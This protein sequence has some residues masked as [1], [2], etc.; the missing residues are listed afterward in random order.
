M[1]YD[2]LRRSANAR[3]PVPSRKRVEGSGMTLE[4]PFSAS[5]RFASKMLPV[6]E[7]VKSVVILSGPR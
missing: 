3:I 7:K 6:G 4:L 2:R 1:N 5:K